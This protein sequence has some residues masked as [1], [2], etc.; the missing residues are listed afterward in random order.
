MPTPSSEGGWRPRTINATISQAGR[1]QTMNHSR[2]LSSPFL[3]LV[4]ALATPAL[5]QQ[6]TQAQIG[7][8]RSS[9]AADYRAHCA[10]VPT[11]GMASLNCLQKNMSKLSAAC[12]SAVSAVGGGAASPSAAAP[13]SPSAAP[14]ASPAEAAPAAPAA[15][16]AR[17][18]PPMSP[19][20][21][22]AV[23]R[24]ACGPDYRALCGGVP[25][26]GGRVVACLREN[27]ASLSPRCQ[28]VLMAARRR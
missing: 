24:G 15:P 26:G 3:V 19:R 27:A 21:E 23:L 25:P 9:C 18:F 10:S 28:A 7:A 16:S 12:Q 4:L 14:S 1:C 8:I 11:G 13:A 20:Q 2:S 22:I 5:A 6:P 17:A